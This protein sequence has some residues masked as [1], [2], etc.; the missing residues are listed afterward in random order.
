M[1]GFLL[2]TNVVSELT[3]G[4]PN[5]KV[6]AWIDSIDESLLYLSVL[7]V[8]EIRKGLALLPRSAR[9]TRYEAWLET[10]LR[11][12]FAGRLLGID[13]GLAERWGGLTAQA[14]KAHHRVPVIDGLLA[15]TAIHYNLTFATR[16]A[17]DVVHTGVP[18]F[19]PWDD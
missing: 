15:A 2:D 9:R 7:S 6:R 14:A 17:D 4:A 3:T 1:P 11:P 8:G 12:R 13:L 5:P 16:N 10:D 19:N 18:V